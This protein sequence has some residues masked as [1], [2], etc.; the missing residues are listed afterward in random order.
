M[1]NVYRT[2]SAALLPITLAPFA[3]GSLSP[4][5]DGAFIGMIIIHTYIGFR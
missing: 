4:V 3:A 5:L 2:L 1:L